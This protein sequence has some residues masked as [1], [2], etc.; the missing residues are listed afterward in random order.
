MH[1]KHIPKQPTSKRPH[2]I[3]FVATDVYLKKN[4]PCAM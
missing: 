4:K 2:L 3:R 1:D